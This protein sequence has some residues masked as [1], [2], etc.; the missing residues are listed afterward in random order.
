M[1][2]WVYYLVFFVVEATAFN[3]MEVS[4]YLDYLP[5][6]QEG[7]AAWE[8]FRTAAEPPTA[9]R[10]RKM[11]VG[12]LRLDVEAILDN[13]VWPASW[14]YSGEDFRPFDYT[15]DEVLN[16]GAQYVYS[17][18]LIQSDQIQLIPGL[19]RVPIRRHFILPK[20]KLAWADHLQYHFSR[21]QNVSA[22]DAGPRVLEL[23][24]CYDS[25]LPSM[26]LGPTVGVGWSGDEMRC[27]GVLDDWIEQDLTVDP[28]L[29][30]SSNFFDFVVMPANAQLLQSPKVMFQEMNRVLKPGGTAFVGLKLAHW[31]FLSQKQGR[32]FAETNY[33]EDIL[34][35]GSFFHFAE[36][37]SKPTSTDLTLPE[38]TAVGKIKDLFFPQPRL[39]FFAVIQARKLKSSP[40]PTMGA[41]DKQVTEHA[42]ILE[43][44]IVGARYA[45]RVVT[46]PA[47]GEQRLGPFY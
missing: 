42:D 29:P 6:R 40:H 35:L 20:D 19:L 13:P 14:P 46:N 36:G 5:Y 41:D 38:Y 33:L 11:E 34:A 1:S 31:S 23:F 22:S 10:N 39:D 45:P 47:T 24:S 18:S 27:N 44:P 4:H 25:I 28:Y 2:P 8:D 21:Y 15:R 3:L 16:T 12:G 30:I 7:L 26:D 37:F 17:Q 9:L 43:N 32:Y